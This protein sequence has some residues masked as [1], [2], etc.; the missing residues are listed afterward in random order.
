MKN[1][2]CLLFCIAVAIAFA[3]CGS[4]MKDSFNDVA[5][6]NNLRNETISD[7]YGYMET[8]DISM[9]KIIEI[10]EVVEWINNHPWRENYNIEAMPVFSNPFHM[11]PDDF[12]QHEGL[13][14][15]ALSAEE[16]TAVAE[17]I[18]AA[19][20]LEVIN[21]N[22]ASNAIWSEGITAVAKDIEVTVEANGFVQVLF[23]NG[24]SL[25]DGLMFSLESS[26]DE[27]I[28]YLTEWFAPIL[29]M[30]QTVFKNNNDD[31]V[32][33]ILDYHFNNI[34]FIPNSN[35][36]LW[37][38]N[39]YTTFNDVLSEKIGYFPIITPS[40]AIERMLN[41]QGSFGVD[42]GQ[43]IPTLD[44][45]IDIRLVYFGHSLGRNLLEEF[46]PWYELIIQKNYLNYW[47]SYFVPAIQS[48]YLEANPAWFFYPHQ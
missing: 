43:R 28:A 37:R 25:P 40:E 45:V 16:M 13:S 42:M 19:M 48:D 1:V 20:E 17:N 31:I 38:I 21:V 18:I 27:A 46:A 36:E 33:R 22:R 2:L 7:E 47:Q 24:F 6:D 4:Q 5:V 34:H 11:L 41:A 35:G 23:V 3:G 8:G 30:E 29:G 44:E 39:M 12:A 9:P 26:S 32:E 10:E 15:N 14:A